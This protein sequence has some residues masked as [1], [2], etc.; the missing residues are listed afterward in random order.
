MKRVDSLIATLIGLDIAL[1]HARLR[2]QAGTDDEALHDLRIGL[3]R[4]RSLLAPLRRIA[5]LPPLYN[6]A[7]ALGSL[8]APVR[9]LEVLAKELD[10]RGFPGLAAERRA[11]LPERYAAVLD[12]VELERLRALLDIW[13]EELR[14]AQR[15][16]QLRRLKEQIGRR[17]HKQVERLVTALA[18]PGYDR[19]RLRLLIKRVRYAGEAYPQLSGLS[20]RS[21][22]ALRAT[23]S[24]LGDWHDHFQWCARIEREPDLAPL[25]EHWRQ[26]AEQALAEGER[27]LRRLTEQLEQDGHT[28]PKHD[29]PEG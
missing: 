16:G 21:I 3:Q 14:D 23:Q 19:H 17:L 25:E 12:S 11:R 2:L 7:A 28:P 20:R 8:S 6:A 9:D 10:E 27:A 26:C 24:A 5:D 15:D 4:L 13:P 18:T 29:R 22:E 1:L